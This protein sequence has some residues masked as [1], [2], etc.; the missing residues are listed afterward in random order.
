MDKNELRMKLSK[1]IIN[2]IQY[3]LFPIMNNSHFKTEHDLGLKKYYI[4]VV[5]FT[6]EEFTN[7]SHSKFSSK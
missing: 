2:T 3:K 1:N 6:E 7:L 5:N 4:L